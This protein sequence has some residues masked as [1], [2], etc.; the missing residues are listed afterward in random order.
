MAT[1]KTRCANA[2]GEKDGRL[3]APNAIMAVCVYAGLLLRLSGSYP[4]TLVSKD[5][6]ECNTNASNFRD[7][8]WISENKKE[9]GK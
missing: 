2:D 3:A 4:L 1:R 9:K 8:E 7:K 5:A 6:N